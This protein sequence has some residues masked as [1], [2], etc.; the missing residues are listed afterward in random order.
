MPIGKGLPRR[1]WRHPKVPIPRYVRFAVFARDGHFCWLCGRITGRG[2]DAATL[3]H[4]IPQ[5]RGGADTVDN[6][7]VAHKRCN[8]QRGD[9]EAV[10]FMLALAQ[11]KQGDP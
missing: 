7:R 8:E 5:A 9:A 3:D 2:E 10:S 6:L 1:Q 11:Q 4:V